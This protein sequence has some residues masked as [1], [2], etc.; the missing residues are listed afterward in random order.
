LDVTELGGVVVIVGGEFGDARHEV[1]DADLVERLAEAAA[2]D[3]EVVA[4]RAER[5]D[6][7]AGELERALIVMSCPGRTAMRYQSV[8]G[9]SELVF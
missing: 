9:N 2:A 8:G 6:F 3:A 4:F 1:G 7:L 5:L